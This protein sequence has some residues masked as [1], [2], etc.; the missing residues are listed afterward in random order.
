[1]MPISFITHSCLSGSS[2]RN[3]SSA[4]EQRRATTFSS[5]RNKL[6]SAPPPKKKKK[7]K[8]VNPTWGPR[9]KQ[10]V[11]VAAGFL[12]GPANAEGRHHGDV[13]VILPHNAICQRGDADG[14]DFVGGVCDAARPGRLPLLVGEDGNVGALAVVGGGA[15]MNHR[16]LA[17]LKL[18]HGRCPSSLLTDHKLHSKLVLLGFVGPVE[19]DLDLELLSP[20]HDEIIGFVKR[21]PVL[22]PV[23][24]SGL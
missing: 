14:E 3:T 6:D 22:L 17:P 12:S 18:K 23:G 8:K 13:H 16:L 4:E 10:D 24:L 19:G 2:S 5:Q 9:V 1:M 15:W 7:R 11:E 21:G 20:T